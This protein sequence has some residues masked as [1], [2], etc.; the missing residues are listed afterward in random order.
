M[1]ALGAH[2]PSLPLGRVMR[3]IECK[4]WQ[5]VISSRLNSHSRG[6]LCIQREETA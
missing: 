6:S 4:L 2:R 3:K 5:T 1:I